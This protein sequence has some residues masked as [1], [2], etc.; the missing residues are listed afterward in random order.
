[1]ANLSN[2]RT[3]WHDGLRAFWCNRQPAVAIAVGGGSGLS[4][5]LD[6]TRLSDG[7]LL[8]ERSQAAARG[9]AIPCREGALP[10]ALYLRDEVER[11]VAVTFPDPT[12]LR[13]LAPDAWRVRLTPVKFFSLTAVPVCDL[14]AYFENGALC[15]TSHK[16]YLDFSGFS[17]SMRNMPL[18]LNLEGRLARTQSREPRHSCSLEGSVSLSLRVKLPFPLCLM[19]DRAISLVGNRIVGGILTRMQ[20]KLLRGLVKDYNVWQEIKEQQQ[21]AAQKELLTSQEPCIQDKVAVS[22]GYALRSSLLGGLLIG[23][24]ASLLL[25]TTGRTMDAS[26]ILRGTLFPEENGVRWRVAFLSSLGMVAGLA[27]ALKPAIFGALTHPGQSGLLMPALSGLLVGFGS[28]M[29]SVNTSGHGVRGL[30]ILSRRSLAAVVTSMTAGALATI[31]SASFSTAAPLVPLPPFQAPSYFPKLFLG[32]CMAVNLLTLFSSIL[33]DTSQHER[34]WKRDIAA[35]VSGLLFGFGLCLS[36]MLDAEKVQSFLR[37]SQ[38]WDPSLACVMGGAIFPN[39]V[40]VPLIMRRHDAPRASAAS[41][42]TRDNI[43]KDLILG[44]AL[45]GFGWGLSG[46][47]PAPGIMQLSTGRMGKPLAG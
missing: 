6:V 23:A 32:A 45:F 3:A 16:L 7:Q 34:S 29:G 31:A 37:L 30:S 19:S 26:S 35:S 17:S 22:S 47:Y 1:M 4:E 21:A 13:R 12:R 9:V 44:A 36:G 10:V 8:P 28:Q 27:A 43:T 42:P 39:L 25:A 46:V 5:E 38:D 15:M 20:D 11:V 14:R 2:L 24:A 33:Q 41:P 40:F 18:D